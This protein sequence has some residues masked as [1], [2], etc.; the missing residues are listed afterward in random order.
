VSD[1]VIFGTG[2]FAREVHQ[3]VLDQNA[4]RV[5]WNLLGFLDGNADRH[6]S[7]VHELPVLG[8][9]TWLARHPAVSVVVAIGATPAKLRVV[10]A[11]ERTGSARFVSLVHPRA[12]IGQG[13]ELGPGCVVCADVLVTTDVRVGRHVILNLVCTVGHDATLADYVTVAPGVNISGSVSVGEGCDLGTGSSVIQGVRIGH[14]C[15]IGAGAVLLHDV[16]PNVTVVGVP[17]RPIKT[18]PEGWQLQ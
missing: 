6:G 9:E 11:I 17:A 13:I 16:A 15:V 7:S 8:D 10:R 2:G 14:W 5:R 4:E 18:R 12:W 1:L 3:I